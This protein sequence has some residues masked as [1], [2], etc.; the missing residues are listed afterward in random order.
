MFQTRLFF[1]LS[2]DHAWPSPMEAA[3]QALCIKRP[4][5]TRHSSRSEQITHFWKLI[6]YKIREKIDI[7]WQIKAL[8]RSHC[9]QSIRANLPA[10]MHYFVV[11]RG[12]KLQIFS[13][14]IWLPAR[15]TA[16]GVWEMAV[17]GPSRTSFGSRGNWLLT[18]LR[19]RLSRIRSVRPISGH[20]KSARIH[21]IQ[22]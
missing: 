12:L 3:L 9:L 18:S 17:R 8:R 20:H 16:L 6:F 5:S 11:G 7:N 22:N 4:L 1:G 13:V 14:F 15:W 10:K 19:N 2:A 21:Q